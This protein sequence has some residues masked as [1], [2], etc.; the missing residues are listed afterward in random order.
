MSPTPTTDPAEYDVVATMTV[1][2]V[3]ISEPPA[4]NIPVTE[5][6]RMGPPVVSTQ[7]GQ[8]GAAAP[9]PQLTFDL[10]EI[11]ARWKTENKRPTVEKI[12]ETEHIAQRDIKRWLEQKG[13]TWTKMLIQYGFRDTK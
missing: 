6:Q 13:L 2:S 7:L 10:H 5:R 12:C 3:D 4:T 1:V 11:V 8:T 9:P